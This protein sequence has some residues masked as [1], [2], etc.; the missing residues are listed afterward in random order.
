MTKVE[1]SAWS[2]D[3]WSILLWSQV[4]SYMY[5]KTDMWSNAYIFLDKTVDHTGRR[6]TLSPI[7]C[8]IY[9][10]SS[11]GLWAAT[12]ASYCPSRQGEL[13]KLIATEYRTQGAAPPCISDLHCKTNFSISQ[14]SAQRRPCILPSFSYSLFI[15][16]LIII[17]FLV[18]VASL[19][20][21]LLFIFTAAFLAFF[22]SK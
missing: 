12:A 15:N 5:N 20:S 10:G 13:P 3:I 16:S 14:N 11:P 2:C 1:Y 19:L 9:L 8:A 18:A 4:G 7:F 21:P 17:D 6:S 22:R